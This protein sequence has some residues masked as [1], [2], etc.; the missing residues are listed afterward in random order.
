MSSHP[1]PGE[2]FTDGYKQQLELM[3][4]Q[5][6]NWG[7]YGYVH[8]SE[9]QKFAATIGAKSVVD[10]GCGKGTMTEEDVGLPVQRYDPGKPE[11]ST[12]PSP[13]DIV[14]CTDVLE[15]IE[16]A[17]LNGV[18]KHIWDLARKGIYLKIAVSESYEILPDG[19]NAHLTVYGVPWWLK[20]LR[21][22][23]HNTIH[24]IEK[25]GLVVWITK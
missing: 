22:M 17:C 25:K 24:H 10:Y 2:L 20:R 7:K 4:V 6:P 8:V 16:P 12:L 23:P 15:H 18:L 21:S 19:R 11:W 9:I 3:H 14:A 5:N 1:V 13:A